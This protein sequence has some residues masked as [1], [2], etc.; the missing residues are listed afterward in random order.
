MDTAFAGGGQDDLDDI[1]DDSDEDR[2]D[3]LE[4]DSDEEDEEEPDEDEPDE[5]EPDEEEPDEEEPDEEEPDE[6]EP[7]EESGRGGRRGGGGRGR[8]GRRPG[9]GRRATTPTTGTT[10]TTATTATT[11]TTPTTRRWGR[12]D[13]SGDDSDGSVGD[14]DG[15]P[16]DY[17][18][19][20]APRAHV[21]AWMGR[22]A[23]DRGLPAELPVMASLV[24]SGMRNLSY[25]DADSVGFFQMRTSI[26]DQGDYAGYADDPELQLEWFL[27]HAEAVRAQRIAN[28]L[29][30]RDPAHYGEWI[31]DV[32][33][34]A[35]Q[36]R[37]R[38]QLQLEE[39]REMLAALDRP[40]AEH[41]WR[42]PARSRPWP[43]PSR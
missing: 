42:Q 37:G 24:E 14:L 32:E 21:A 36:F 41:G 13:D 27:D 15:A 11:P 35:A 17:P 22:A 4:R 25:G 1:E 29:P 39:A 30:V 43:P 38:Y 18:G 28:G 31:A 5:E 9:R 33:R 8:R 6:D 20:D 26:W 40:R 10:S 23:Q 34:P 12:R 19:D 3:D 7:D 2:E 16:S